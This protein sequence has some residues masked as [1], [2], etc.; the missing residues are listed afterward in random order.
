M[1]KRKIL[2]FL[3]ILLTLGFA[4]PALGQSTEEE[5]SEE[6]VAEETETTEPVDT[7][8][9]LN[10]SLGGKSTAELGN[11]FWGFLGDQ[12]LLAG[13][14]AV[15]VDAGNPS[16]LY[17]GGPGY[18]AVSDDNGANWEERFNYSDSPE[19]E[20]ADSE[21]AEGEGE[22]GEEDNPAKDAAKVAA[23]REYLRQE[24]ENQFDTD[25][26]DEIL[27]DITDDELLQA[28]DINEIDALKEL[29]LDMDPDLTKVQNDS[30]L[31]AGVA[32]SEFDSYIERFIKYVNSGAER[33]AAA[34]MAG[35]ATA[36]SQFITTATET[37]A[38]TPDMVYFSV[39]K[40]AN[41][42]SFMPAPGGLKIL[43]MAISPDGQIVAVGLTSGMLITRDGGENWTQ[44][45]DV[46]PGGI[47]EIYLNSQTYWALST[48]GIYRS[49]DRGLTWESVEGPWDLSEYV[50]DM[51]AGSGSSLLVL[52]NTTLY[53]S[54]DAR[55][56]NAIPTDAISDTSIRQVISNDPTLRTFT[57]RTDS[58]VYQ[59]G[60]NGWISQN[61]SLNATELGPLVE[62]SDGYSFMI[63]ASPSGLWLAQDANQFVFTPEYQTLHK[64]WS[65]EPS[66]DMVIQ[67][68]L[69]AHYLGD[70]LDNS[71]GMRNRLSWLLPFVGVE[72]EYMQQKRDQRQTVTN[73]Q[74]AYVTSDK[75]TFRRET[76]WYL[77]VVARWNLKLSQGVT[78]EASAMSRMNNLKKKREALIK[79]V[80]KDLN[81]R[82]AYQ[83]TVVL[84]FPKLPNSKASNKKIAKTTL[85]LQEIEANL[86]FMTGGYYM[87]AIH[88]GDNQP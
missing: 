60:S 58:H 56:F 7:P 32:V 4:S 1:N 13:T 52:T 85:G 53:Y 28:K 24:L 48:E 55:N 82:R 72:Y 62:L 18:I 16:V 6:A 19:D 65:K 35:R 39:D 37:Y 40:G 36:V 30:E 45:D 34:S 15:A 41:W 23:L 9:S 25:Y 80:Q 77:Q 50:I 14:T 5:T 21:D 69:D 2:C 84:D 47:F 68:A 54:A 63:M 46:I 31:I 88:A 8:S 73:M 67:K 29:E 64:Q 38:V 81:R 42:Q 86:H 74:L 87:T 57:V 75:Y 12:V 51:V 33:N 11:Y 71:W 27:E 10:F 59:F 22:T 70:I 61:N 79:S 43:S 20:I 76:T 66:D 3:G 83:M 44:L 49:S 17:A 78:E 26:A